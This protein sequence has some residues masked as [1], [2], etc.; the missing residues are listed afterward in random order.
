MEQRYPWPLDLEAVIRSALR[1]ALAERSRDGL[2]LCLVQLE[3]AS[4]SDL[5]VPKTVG[6]IEYFTGMPIRIHGEFFGVV[7]G[8]DVCLILFLPRRLIVLGPIVL[9]RIGR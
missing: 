2:D 5:Y 3:Q 8:W 6:R 7:K 9:I 1:P 4:P